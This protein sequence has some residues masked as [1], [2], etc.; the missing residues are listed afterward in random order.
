MEI[1]TKQD[2]ENIITEF[3]KGYS[4]KYELDQQQ[5]K[6]RIIQMAVSDNLEIF[7]LGEGYSKPKRKLSD[8]IGSDPFEIF[9]D[10]KSKSKLQ[11][12]QN[13]KPDSVQNSP[14]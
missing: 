9:K 6:T 1:E 14:L 5:R 2:T 11:L 7:D 10:V 4:W 13:Q 3:Q 8:P 12:D